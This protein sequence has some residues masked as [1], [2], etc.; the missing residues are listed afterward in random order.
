MFIFT[1]CERQMYLEF[2]DLKLF[3]IKNV[4]L[5]ICEKI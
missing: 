2:I 1:T 5:H 3:F 4:F